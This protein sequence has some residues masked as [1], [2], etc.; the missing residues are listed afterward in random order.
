MPSA[1]SLQANPRAA[2]KLK[3]L[4][5]SGVI[6]EGVK[7]SDIY[8]DPD[9]ARFINGMSHKAIRRRIKICLK[10]KK[11]KCAQIVR[12]ALLLQRMNDTLY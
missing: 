12:F 1:D 4:V 10:R 11:P 3:Q 2:R 5:D 6:K 7:P 9:F 8:D